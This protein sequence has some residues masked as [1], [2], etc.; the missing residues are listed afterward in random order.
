MKAGAQVTV[1]D[2]NAA[3]SMLGLPARAT[4]VAPTSQ[5]LN[6]AN[7]AREAMQPTPSPKSSPKKNKPPQRHYVIK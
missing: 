5:H 2:V 7:A 6:A 4:S 3:I 1:D